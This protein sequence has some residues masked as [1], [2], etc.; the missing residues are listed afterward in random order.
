MGPSPERALGFSI[1]GPIGR[2]DLDSLCERIC[3]LFAEQQ[4]EV[5]VCDVQG[6]E[7][8][9]VTVEALARL[10]LA[11]RRRGCVV[12][13]QGA[14]APLRELVDLMGLTDVLADHETIVG[15]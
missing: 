11:A 8:D 9:A 12:R 1:R 2:D 13:L 15:A 7:P 10:Q 5:A 3:A 14:S 4:P 6:V